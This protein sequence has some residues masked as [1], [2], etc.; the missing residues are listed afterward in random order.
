MAPQRGERELD[1]DQH[2]LDALDADQF[3]TI[4]KHLLQRKPGL[5]NKIRL[6][7]GDRLGECGFIGQQLAAHPRPLR[8]LAGIQEHRARPAGAF[9]AADGAGRRLAG[10]QCPQSGH[11]LGAL[12]GHHRGELGMPGPVVVECVRDIG[13]RDLG[14][15]A[16]H[17]IGQYRG[18]RGH[19]LCCLA[20]DHQRRH[21]RRRSRLRG[22]KIGRLLDDHMRIRPADTERG[23][24]GS[25]RPAGS[26]PF[27]AVR[28]D[29]QPRYALA[30]VRCQLLEV[31]V[32]G[33][34]TVAQRQHGFHESGDARR[35][36]EMSE[37]GLHRSQHQRLGAFPIA[38]N[39]AQRVEFDWVTERC[40]GAVRLDVV[41]VGRLQLGGRQRLTKQCLLRR[42]VGH[43]HSAAGAVLVDR[44]TTDHRQDVIAVALRIGQSLEDH[45]T[46]ALATHI[47]VGG[48][49]EGLALPLGRQ[50]SPPRARDAGARAEQQVGAT[51]Q[52]RVAFTPAQALTGQVDGHQRRRACRV[53]HDSGTPGPEQICH[54]PGGEVRRVAGEHI[55]VEVFGSHDTGHGEHVVVGGDTDE[56]RGLGPADGVWR[57]ARV[58]Q[59]F[60]GHF[61][62]QPLLRVHRRSLAWGD[63]E[64]LRIEL[65]RLPAGEEAALPVADRSRDGVVLGVERVGVPAL[66]RNP[67]DA[68]SPVP[69]QLPV[70]IGVVDPTG[71][72]AAH[73]DHGHRFG[74][75]LFGDLQPCGEIV[76]LVQRLG[77]NSP[78]IWCRG[79]HR[80]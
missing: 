30:G 7:L 40:A 41:D 18:G 73:S 29:A 12:A 55:G 17:P 21:R 62:E 39:L 6:Q 23:H 67:D 28:R 74:A 78:A 33:D 58:F 19:P 27:H 54:P 2:R 10:G 48:G 51:D 63:R 69:Q 15:G 42:P 59:R 37:V 64:E 8:T 4:G 47:A 13:Q 77:D 34:V 75:G 65:I 24:S 11:R 16:V 3:L 71:Q 49:V 45:D 76:D 70:L 32:P 53:E 60:Q 66:R 61:E 57:D 1:G 50:H 79:R 22:R 36:L 56:D 20:G 38:E 80:V 44:R 72:P 25:A 43:G 52:R 35:S 14:A 9:V 5:G 31:Q 46:A 26:W 68:A